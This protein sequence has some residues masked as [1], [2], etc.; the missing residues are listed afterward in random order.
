M[1]PLV[2]CLG[3]RPKGA[4]AVLETRRRL[5]VRM[6]RAGQSPSAVA[7]LLDVDRV[8]IWRWKTARRLAARPHPGAPPRLSRSQRQAL[9]QL[10]QQDPTA[11][12]WPTS[13]W[14]CPRVA[15][16]IRRYFGVQYHPAHVW[17][18]L[19]S[20]GLSKQKPQQCARERDEAAIRYWRGYRWPA[21]KK[22]PSRRVGG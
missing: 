4:A 7:Q 9:R 20:L 8:T 15:S 10:L 13:L 11:Y 1:Q 16:L 17:R 2:L 3:M 18:L 19:R 5:A 6:L 21:I 12:G 22:G 14:T